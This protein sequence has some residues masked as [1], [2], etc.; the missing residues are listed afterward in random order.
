M[1]LINDIYMAIKSLLKSKY[2]EINIYGNEVTEGF[3][4]PS[5]FIS[6]IPKQISNEGINFKLKAYTV[7]INYFQSATNE[8]DNLQKA[9][10]IFE[11]FGYFL[12]VNNKKLRITDSDYEFIGDNKNILQIS[13]NIEYFEA[14]EKT[15][16]SKVA[17]K[18]SLNEEKR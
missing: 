17:Q 14:N 11:L 16:T 15:E 12:T 2:P 18:I 5:Y 3:D 4:K 1:I 6:L 8:I 7:L 13:I 9:D 10:E